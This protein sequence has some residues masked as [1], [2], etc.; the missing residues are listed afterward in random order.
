MGIGKRVK[1]YLE[2]RSLKEAEEG[3]RE[4]GLWSCIADTIGC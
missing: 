1:S 2:M 4:S 3:E